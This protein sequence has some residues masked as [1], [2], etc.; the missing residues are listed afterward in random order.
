MHNGFEVG[1][2][3]VNWHWIGQG[4]FVILEFEERKYTEDDLLFYQRKNEE[5][6]LPIPDIKVGEVYAVL[7]VMRRLFTDSGIKKNIKK[8]NSKIYKC[9]V[10]YIRKVEPQTLDEKIIK[11]TEQIKDVKE[12]VLKH[13]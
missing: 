11:Y 12:Y 8:Y 1:N 4:Y 3:V 13:N 9:D 10:K 2:L 7:A 6:G 5:L